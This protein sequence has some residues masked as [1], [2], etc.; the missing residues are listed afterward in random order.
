MKT[1]NLL[2]VL[3]TALLTISG[4]QAN[5]QNDTTIVQA[6]SFSTP[7]PPS[8]YRG[9]FDF[10]ENGDTY[11]KILMYYTLKCD[12][13]T[14]ADQFPCGE[15]DYLSYVYVVDSAGVMDSTRRTQ[16]NYTLASG[17]TP[18]STEYT[19]M[20]TYTTFQEWQYFFTYDDTTSISNAIIGS[21]TQVQTP[22]LGASKQTGR[23]QF[24]WTSSELVG[25]GVAA[26]DITGIK[27]YVESAG[28]ELRNLAIKM[29][30]TSL[31]SLSADSHETDG[32]E[33]TYR[34]NTTIQNAGWYDFNFTTPFNWDGTSNIVIEFTYNNNT[35]GTDSPVEGEALSWNAGVTVA[36]DEHHIDCNGS[37]DYANLGRGDHQMQGN[38]PRTI[39]AW[40]YAEGFNNGGIFQAGPTG[41][42]GR[43]FS[44]RTTGTDNL[45]R[46]QMW[47]TPDFD[48]TLPGSKD[49]WH[50]Y[51]ITYD[52]NTTRM[53]YD[54]QLMGQE[55]Y[56]LNTGESDFLLGRWNGTEFNGK[57]DEVRVW[58]KA[59]DQTTIQEWMDK[60]VSASHPDYANLKAYYPMNEGNG[61]MIMDESGNGNHGMLWGAPQWE[62]KKPG[63]LM[64]DLSETMNRPNV[65]FEQGVFTI[66]TDSILSTETIENAPI[67]LI[68]FGNVGTGGII[69]ENSPDHPNIPTDTLTVWPA[70]MYTYT[71]DG[72]GNAIDSTFIA[73]E[74][75]MFREDIEYFSRIVWYEI[76]RF[77]TPYGIN[78]DLGDDGFTWVFDV[79]DYEPILHGDVY[80]QAGNNQE[81]LDLRFVMVKGDPPRDV[82]K[83]QNIWSGNWSYSSI[84]DNINAAPVR[85]PLDPNGRMFRVKTRSSGHG[86]DNP[87]NCAEF[88]PKTHSLQVDGQTRF[89]WYLWNECATNPVYPQG[90]TWIYDRAGWCPGDIV[91]TYNH[92][93]TPYVTPGD[94]VELDYSVASPGPQGAYGNYVVRGQ[95]VTYGDANHALDIAMEEIVSPNKED[96]YNRF[97]PTCGQPVIK[98]TNRG[99]E[100]VT[101]VLINFGVKDGFQDCHYQWEGELGFMESEEITL[102]NFN[103]TGANTANPIFFAEV[104]NPNDG[105]DEN[106]SNDRMEAYFDVV[107]EYASGLII[108]IKSNNFGQESRYS[109]KDRDGN[110]YKLRLSLNN[111]TTYLDTLELP[112]GCYEFL[113][114]DTDQD[115]ISWWA[116]NDG[117][118]YAKILSP[119][120]GEYIAFD[121]D[122]GDNIHHEFTVGYEQGSAF[123]DIPCEVS[124][125][126]EDAEPEINKY[127]SIYPNPAKDYINVDLEFPERRDI[128]VEVY[129]SLGQQ[130]F[131]VKHYNFQ[132]GI[133]PVEMPSQAGTYFVKVRTDKDSY[134]ET[135][136]VTP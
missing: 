75:T 66:S 117:A 32:F 74:N 10:P 30:H 37:T 7:A 113:M 57:I 2:V 125:S 79:T 28:S 90:G 119:F 24:L 54:G 111:N 116:N 107:P 14:Q 25:A 69:D 91:N 105:V 78:L 131:D 13:S 129:N 135:V 31:D 73:I 92:E 126:I 134:T 4:F 12:P 100:P 16:R 22:P 45:W 72:L 64:L 115:G 41:T 26:G 99:S 127:V 102:P 120:G 77:I 47:G 11:E 56:A 17:A 49:A 59:L 48:V 97:N 43:D 19:S 55:A 44:L 84:W 63:E 61:T 98:I 86:F 46:V 123:F 104:V 33:T 71:Y 65:N 68:V 21:G 93:L 118:G 95:L 60:S 23:S 39:E 50:H 20:P 27:L 108:E 6:F 110:T 114:T 136:I 35:P 42:T 96:L 88:C 128:V 40:A 3:L 130:L 80:I 15:W 9:T 124:T 67:Q 1:K 106:P 85:I 34:I 101:K 103:W 133:L 76:G 36:A 53:Y 8:V 112:V 58:D 121:P 83:V 51:C 62:R 70:N 109:V 82:M 132:T 29:R 87:T 18:D 94:T 5:A 81:L 122:F 52:G 38:V 89:N